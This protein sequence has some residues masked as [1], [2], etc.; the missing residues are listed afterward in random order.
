MLSQLNNI[1]KRKDAVIQ[2]ARRLAKRH[3]IAAAVLF[4][5][6][7]ISFT[8]PMVNMIFLSSFVDIS[9]ERASQDIDI[10]PEPGSRHTITGKVREA[11]ADPDPVGRHGIEVGGRVDETGPT[12]STPASLAPPAVRDDS[13]KETA[14]AIIKSQ[15]AVTK[16]S[17]SAAQSSMGGEIDAPAGA[18]PDVKKQSAADH[19]KTPPEK[20]SNA[21]SAG[22]LASN[23][24]KKCSPDEEAAKDHETILAAVHKYNAGADNSSSSTDGNNSLTGPPSGGESI[25]LSGLTGQK[26]PNRSSRLSRKKKSRKRNHPKHGDQ[27]TN[28]MGMQFVWIS[29][30]KFLMGTRKKYVEGVRDEKLHHVTLTK[31]FYLQTTE[32]SQGQW[33]AVMKGNPSRFRKLGL[34]YPVENVSWYDVQVFIKQLN[35]MLG[36]SSYRLPTEA[37]WEFAARA[38]SDGP[39]SFGS[40]LSTE[41]SNFDGRR[42]MDGCNNGVFRKQTLRTGR[43]SPNAW[44][45]FDMHGNVMEWCQDYYGSY[46]AGDTGDPKGPGSGQYRAVRGGGWYSIADH[47]RSSFRDFDR[48]ERRDHGIGFRLVLDEYNIK[49]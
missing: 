4:A 3:V 47:C 41:Q 7:G 32:V 44:G 38:G 5:L 45:L 34:D 2:F 30:G 48:P 36:G 1:L 35:I 9:L 29:P 21:G 37:E 15:K 8:W 6:A 18:M 24:T 43:F 20:E 27:Y 23:R 33:V 13:H 17:D 16:C 28:R 12:D 26:S 19:D 42:N 25:K 10:K 49:P 14:T 39:F 22:G 31:G 46:D 11:P 40:C